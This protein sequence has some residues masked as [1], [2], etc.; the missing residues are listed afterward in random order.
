MKKEPEKK[1]DYVFLLTTHKKVIDSRFVKMGS[2]IS[3]LRVKHYVKNILILIPLCCSGQLMTTPD[4]I[5]MVALAFLS[6]SLI[7]SAIYIINDIQDK[8]KDA[9][10]PKKKFRAIASGTV[11]TSKAITFSVVL[12]IVA[13]GLSI[14]ISVQSS[15]SV[16]AILL[17]YLILNIAYSLRLKH[18]P[19]IEIAI[20]TNFVVS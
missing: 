4:L 3:L 1:P 8:G 6:F 9:Q 19:I 2:L 10:H 17:T 16:A 15:W 11:K 12:A 18:V 20:Y 14:Y 7:S 5:P 13:I